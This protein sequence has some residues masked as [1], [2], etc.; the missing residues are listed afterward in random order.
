MAEPKTH[1]LAM[2]AQPHGKQDHLAEGK[3]A[4]HP[5]AEPVQCS[6]CSAAGRVVPT[7]SFPLLS[8]SP[9]DKNRHCKLKNFSP[10]LI[11]KPDAT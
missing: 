7:S 1:W 8:P 4:D 6:G 3:S 2:K 11:L 9:V 10:G 5:S